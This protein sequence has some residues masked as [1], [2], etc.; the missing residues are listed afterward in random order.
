MLLP[1]MGDGKTTICQKL[2]S[3]T[4]PLKMEKEVINPKICSTETLLKLKAVLKM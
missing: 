1:I 3:G 4:K 2:K